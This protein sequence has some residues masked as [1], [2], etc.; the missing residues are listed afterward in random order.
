MTFILGLILFGCSMFIGFK[1]YTNIKKREKFFDDF[2][3]F[4]T[5]LQAEIGFFKNK[6]EQ[7][8]SKNDY[9]NEFNSLLE[10]AKENLNNEKAINE[11]CDNQK[12]L[13]EEDKTQ[14]ITFFKRLGKVDAISQKGE[15]IEYSNLLKNKIN[16][17]KTENTKKAKSV[18]SL[19]VMLGLALF[20]IVI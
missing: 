19:S 12:Y 2:N 20:I 1:I 14:I 9:G 3:S 15:I 16:I 4:C 13:N 17:I 7:I 5:I 8:Y 10:C 18:L 6:L 11:W